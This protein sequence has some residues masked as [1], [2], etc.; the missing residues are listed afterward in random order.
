MA[1]RETSDGGLHWA[2]PLETVLGPALLE[3][4]GP[5]VSAFGWVDPNEPLEGG[6]GTPRVDVSHIF[7]AIH[8]ALSGDPTAWG[9]LNRIPLELTGTPFQNNVWMALR[10]I[11]FGK[12]CSYGAL[13]ERLGYRAS[14]A[15]AVGTACGSNPLALFVPC[16]RILSAAGRLSGF[17]WGLARKR[18]LLT[19]EQSAQVALLP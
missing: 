17:K 6:S 3:G 4:F 1:Q 14:S 13:A 10:T 16:H 9:A 8:A 11:P 2:I 5:N 18:T 15:R 19:L 7:E 12:T